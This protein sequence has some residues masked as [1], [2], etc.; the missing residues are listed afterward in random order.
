VPLVDVTFTAWGKEHPTRAGYQIDHVLASPSVA[1]AIAAPEV[2][3]HG[4]LAPAASD[5]QAVQW[6]L[7]MGDGTTASVQP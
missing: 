3:R 7:S 2:I 4:V 5:H 1:A 6:C